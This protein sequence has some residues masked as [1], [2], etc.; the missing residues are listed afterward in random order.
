M[1]RAIAM[2]LRGDRQLLEIARGHLQHW[3][4][5][6]GRSTPYLTAWRNILSLPFDTLL[7]TIQEDSERMA[8]LRQYTPLAGLLSAG[9]RWQIYARAPA[10]APAAPFATMKTS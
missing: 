5:R 1:H 7:E 10:G 9:E 4:G 8:T 6:D 3:T 2:K